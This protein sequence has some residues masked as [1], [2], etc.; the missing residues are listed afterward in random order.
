MALY[1]LALNLLT[2]ICFGMIFRILHRKEPR[3]KHVLYFSH[4]F[5]HCAAALAVDIAAPLAIG[6]FLASVGTYLF[7][8]FAIYAIVKGIFLRCD[9]PFAA[10]TVAGLLTACVLVLIAVMPLHSVAMGRVVTSLLM[11]PVFGISMIAA[12][13]R[14]SQAIDLFVLANLATGTLIM[15]VHPITTGLTILFP[16]IFG[17]Y[18]ETVHSLVIIF[19][20]SLLA[21]PLGAVLLFATAMEIFTKLHSI[22]IIDGLT[23]LLNRSSFEEQAKQALEENHTISLIVCDIDHF[24]RI[25][26]TQG[27]AAGDEVIRAVSSRMKDMCAEGQ[28][29]GRVGGEEFCVL[30]PMSNTESAS[31][32]AESLRLQIALTGLKN[33][34]RAV[35][36]SMGIAALTAGEDYKSLFKRADE[37]LYEA[38][39]SGRDRVCIAGHMKLVSPDKR[40]EKL[41]KA[42]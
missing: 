27:H 8:A 42:A 36:V 19:S 6:H 14:R 34:N 2:L 17:A 29:A 31:L 10:K 23:G 9:R 5:F 30:L 3:L 24:K 16:N 33:G 4:A 37:A 26:D 28:I 40:V 22:S 7:F 20:V 12:A 41:N 18:S 38:K 1:F 39:N 25:N 15:I 21:I 32:F 13:S 11:A 35:T